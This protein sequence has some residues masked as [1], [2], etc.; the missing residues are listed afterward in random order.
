MKALARVAGCLPLLL[1]L[2]GCEAREHAN[3]FDPRNPDTHGSPAFLDARAGNE[4]VLLQWD[5]PG[6]EGVRTANLYRRDLADSSDT[7][8]TR[9]GIDLAARSFVDST[10]H[11]GVGY[12]YRLTLS[13]TTGVDRSSAWDAATPGPAVPWVADADGGGLMRLTPDGRDLVRR[14]E[15]GFWFLDLAADSATSTVWSAEYFGGYLFHHDLDGGRL[16]QSPLDGAR[17]VAVSPDGGD[18]WVASFRNGRIERRAADGTTAWTEITG[19]H[20][21]DL[22]IA[23]DGGLWSAAWLDGGTGEVRL[24]RADRLARTIGGLGRPVA[25]AEADQDLIIVVD[26]TDRRASGFD[27]AGDEVLRS[28]QIFLDPVDLCPDGSGGAW[29]ADPGRGGIVH[30]GQTLEEIRFVALPHVLGITLDSRDDRL[31]AAGENGVQVLDLD[32]RIVSTLSLGGRPVKVEL[33][34]APEVR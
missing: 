28:G 25:I 33:L 14:V 7:L 19:S 27:W 10:V 3:P 23:G 15:T 17:A 24:Y 13:L 30:L 11:N 6:L 26:R 4:E 16:L 34:Y 22:L 2:A 5:V 1:L 18:V 12:E 8:L 32:G 29:I 21:E 31:W 20:I 9:E